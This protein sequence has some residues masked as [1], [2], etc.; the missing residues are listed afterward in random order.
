MIVSELKRLVK[1]CE[2]EPAAF[3]RLVDAYRDERD[4]SELLELLSCPD[5]DLVRIS[6]WILSEV[7]ASKYDT[8]E[9]RTRLFELTRHPNP[10]VRLHSLNALFPFLEP[11]DSNA[12]ELITRLQADDNEGVRMI[13]DAAATRLGVAQ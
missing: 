3:D 12:T 1:N 4:T 5:D 7:R 11:S 6:A 9:F 8:I 13:A 10:A 2:D